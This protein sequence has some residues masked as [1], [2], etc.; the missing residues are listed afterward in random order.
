MKYIVI[1]DDNFW[2]S[3]FEAANQ[4]EIDEHLVEI[5][6]GILNN[7]FNNDTT[8]TKLFVYEY[9]NVVEYEA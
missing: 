2:Y 8:P 5:R 6:L 7:D 9:V 4:T 1:G 3:T